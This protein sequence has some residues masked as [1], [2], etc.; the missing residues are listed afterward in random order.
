MLVTWVS[1]S[2]ENVEFVEMKFVFF[3]IDELEANKTHTHTDTQT[4]T[5]KRGDL[6][7]GVLE[8]VLKS[9]WKENS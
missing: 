9:L 4:H 6:L 2:V 1:V 3:T 7:S 5:P 8:S